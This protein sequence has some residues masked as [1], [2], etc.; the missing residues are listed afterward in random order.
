MMQRTGSIILSGW[1]A[2]CWT[3]AASA[4]TPALEH[5]VVKP[6]SGATLQPTSKAAD[7]SRMPVTFRDGGRSVQR[8]VE[9][10]Y[11]RLDYQLQN[12]R[13]TRNE[14][15]AN[16]EVE[17]KRVGGETLSRTAARMLFRVPRAGGAYSWC[18]IEAGS[19]G[20]Y[21]L[22]IVDEAGLDLSLEFDADALL[23]ALA[24]KGEV[25]IYGILFDVDRAALRPGSGEVV[26]TIASILTA[27][28]TLRL[29]VQGH[30]DNTGTADRNRVL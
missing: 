24:T 10:R 6:M 20:A 5:P 2:V 23:A 21:Q 7:F 29:E 19:N 12:R 16:Y 27:D 28:P 11:W 1:L 13:T 15:M 9:G 30:T 4:Q 14:I 18:R 8:E 25:A 22:E 26:D 3:S 17:A